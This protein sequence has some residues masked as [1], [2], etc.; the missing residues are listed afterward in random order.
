MNADFAREPSWANASLSGLQEGGKVMLMASASTPWTAARIRELPDDGRRYEVIDGSLLVTPAPSWKHQDAIMAL[1][2]LLQA[3]MRPSR[4]GHAIVAPA[5]VEFAADRMVEPDLFV[6][7]LINGRKP[8]TWADAKQLLLAVEV[9]SPTTARVDRDAKRRLYQG[10]RVPEYW[11]VDLDVRIVERWR[12][13]D[14]RPEILATRLTWQ[15]D[16]GQSPLVIDLEH[17]FAEVCDL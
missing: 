8:R 16:A 1:W 4:I 17:L 13:A 7:P 15:P 5:D 14:L 10:E 12:P 3:Y 6:V 9:L 2:Q 11:I